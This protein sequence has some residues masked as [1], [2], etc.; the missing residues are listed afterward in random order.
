MCPPWTRRADRARSSAPAPRRR[1]RAAQD[2]AGTEVQSM[3]PDRTARTTR[4]A[5]SRHVGELC[6]EQFQQLAA[7]TWRRP[8]TRRRR[9]SA[10]AEIRLP[11]A[12]LGALRRARKRPPLEA[13]AQ[14]VLHRRVMAV[15]RGAALAACA[16]RPR[17][18]SRG[19]AGRARGRRGADELRPPPRRTAQPR[20]A[21]AWQAGGRRTVIGVEAKADETLGETLGDYGTGATPGAAERLGLGTRAIAGRP[22]PPHPAPPHPPL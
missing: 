21:R 7:Q 10:A 18:R 20:R 8:A 5:S 13:G 3:G 19:P 15:G 16:S 1:T 12:R 17:T 4:L 9:S 22:P 11:P 6:L 14:R 2:R